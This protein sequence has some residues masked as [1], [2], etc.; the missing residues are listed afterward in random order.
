MLHEAKELLKDSRIENLNTFSKS[1][2]QI[3]FA[4]ASLGKLGPIKHLV[5]DYQGNQLANREFLRNY[6]Y[7]HERIILRKINAFQTYAT[8]KTYIMDF[9]IFVCSIIAAKL[10]ENYFF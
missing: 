8:Y 10:I 5:N 3:L 7:K 9:I 1:F 2:K 6:F 4:A